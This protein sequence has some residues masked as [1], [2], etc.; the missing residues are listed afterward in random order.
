MQNQRNYSYEEGGDTYGQQLA[1]QNGSTYSSS[2]S[3][4]HQS[5]YGHHPNGQYYA[6]SQHSTNTTGADQ[7]SQNY[8]NH[9][10]PATQYGS[11]YQT[12]QGGDP[13]YYSQGY[14]PISY[15][16]Q[17]SYYGSPY[18]TAP[19]QRTQHTTHSTQFIPTPSQTFASSRHVGNPQSS[20]RPPELYVANHD[21]MQGL[22]RGSLQQSAR[23][24]TPSRPRTGTAGSPTSVVGE[25]FPC[26]KCGKTFSRSHDRKRHHETQ[27]LA[28]PV[29]HRCQY[30]EKEFSRADSLKR[31]LDNGC[32]EMPMS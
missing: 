31:H 3:F 18:N 9:P 32:D 13:R 7:G 19:D 1:I 15:G 24:S 11:R 4:G 6:S 27:H 26:E 14:S 20:G 23:T 8:G 12:E 22:S 2:T 10:S 30:C 28:T 21:Q 5:T 25:R 29:M 17:S 16:S